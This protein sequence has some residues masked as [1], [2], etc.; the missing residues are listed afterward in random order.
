MGV[1]QSSH[2]ALLK[3]YQKKNLITIYEF[4]RNYLSL[5]TEE[6]NI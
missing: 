1:F 5:I 4:N 3:Y 2:D 6:L